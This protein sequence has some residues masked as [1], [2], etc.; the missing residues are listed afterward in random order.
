MRNQNYPNLLP[1][2]GVISGGSVTLP[3]SSQPTGKTCASTTI[4]RH[5]HSARDRADRGDGRET[6]LPVWFMK[7]GHPAAQAAHGLCSGIVAVN[8]AK[9]YMPEKRATGIERQTAS[10]R[11]NK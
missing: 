10:Q 8:A 5:S 6:A 2:G 1:I 3:H 11:L 4:A 7:A 9:S